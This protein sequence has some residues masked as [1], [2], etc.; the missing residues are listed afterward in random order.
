LNPSAA[1][2]GPAASTASMKKIA[3]TGFGRIGA[4]MNAQETPRG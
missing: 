4:R 3:K 2:A 1:A